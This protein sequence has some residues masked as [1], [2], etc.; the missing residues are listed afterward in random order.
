M[1]RFG[2][3]ERRCTSCRRTLPVDRFQSR[4][5]TKKKLRKQCRDCRTN[6]LDGPCD[7]PDSK[8]RRLQVQAKTPKHPSENG[9]GSPPKRPRI[10]HDG[11]Q[12]PAALSTSTSS[13]IKT[14]T[15][16]SS[17]TANN[18][19]LSASSSTAPRITSR[20][21]VSQAIDAAMHTTP[22][23]Y[24]H[25]PLPGLSFSGPVDKT[26]NLQQQRR[27]L[28]PPG[29]TRVAHSD[30]PL[31]TSPLES[32]IVP[33]SPGCLE[34]TLKGIHC[35]YGAGVRLNGKTRDPAT[36]KCDYCLFTTRKCRG[37]GYE[38]YSKAVTG[39]AQSWSSCW[40]GSALT[41]TRA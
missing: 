12:S 29:V 18:Q 32:G 41:W 37:N 9:Q 35:T 31:L 3:R 15:A 24:H 30:F 6:K 4:K 20:S 33:V 34:C 5:A 26:K 40:I 10:S 17:S 16:P 8:A 27:F 23:I 22:Q 21:A 19:D 28:V 11:A 38:G 7:A 14:V 1:T 25:R 36:G 13:T 2:E 39:R